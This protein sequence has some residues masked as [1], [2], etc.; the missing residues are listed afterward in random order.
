M[1]TKETTLV[2][3]AAAA[4][5]TQYKVKASAA[6]KSQTL[7]ASSGYESLLNT[8]LGNGIVYAG[9]IIDRNWE[10]DF[11]PDI[12]N[13]R[14]LDDL[15][16]CGQIIQFDKPA[17][18]GAWRDYELNQELV[19]DQVS[20]DSFCISICQQAYK[21]IKFDKT[22]IYRACNNWEAFEDGFLNDA[23]RQLSNAWHHDVITGMLIHAS[24][25]NSGSKAG[26][27]NNIDLGTLGNPRELSPENLISF[28]SKTR[29]LLTQAGRWY[30][31]EMFMLVPPS[32]NA[33][34]M[35]TAYAKQWC[36]DPGD[37]VMVKG[38]KTPDLNGF[39][40]YETDKL[41][42]TI[43]G[44]GR[45]IY[46]ILFGWNDAYAFAGDIVEAEINKV[47]RSFGVTY[48]MLA[49]YGGGAIYPEAL[50]KAFVTLTTDG[51]SG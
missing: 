5:S 51:I 17:R 16:R 39:K 50:G 32:F 24:A 41:M 23:W 19:A 11:L 47:P 20:P 29:E 36:C 34:V 30:D 3:I 27:Y 40:V 38:M 25:N 18:V 35:E 26:R 6:N 10:T 7:K 12:T 43:D 28:L 22:D 4:N 44:S 42:P 31:G 33:L 15:L 21:S 2:A 14:V 9:S 1:L 46:P 45:L 13:T 37:S 48:D 49:I 8:N